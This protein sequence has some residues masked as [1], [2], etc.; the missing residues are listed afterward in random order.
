[1][2]GLVL[3]AAVAMIACLPVGA[4]AAEVDQHID[5]GECAGLSEK[6]NMG[7]S[8]KILCEQGIKTFK[9]AFPRALKGDYQAQRNVAF[10]LMSG[11]D[12]AVTINKPLGCAWRAVILGSGSSKVDRSDTSSFDSGC[13]GKLT[14]SEAVVSASQY[15][16]LYRRIYRRVAPPFM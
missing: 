2:R 15:T 6:L 3:A 13:R 16:E 11:C 14:K 8:E 4:I 10:C 9:A 12:G 5:A 7:V 1:M